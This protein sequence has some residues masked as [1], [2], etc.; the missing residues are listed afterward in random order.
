MMRVLTSE[1]TG[2]TLRSCGTCFVAHKV[3]GLERLERVFSKS[4]IIKRE[5]ERRS[6]LG[7]DN[8]DHLVQIGTEASPLP[9]WNSSGAVKVWW[10]DKTRRITAKDTHAHPAP[11]SKDSDECTLDTT[12]ISLEDWAD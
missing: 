9:Q 11:K 10:P 12:P 2:H 1:D 3:S 4:K 8:L 7:E 6:R 5:R